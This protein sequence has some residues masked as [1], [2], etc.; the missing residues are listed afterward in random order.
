M[1]VYTP[2]K[3]GEPLWER[4]IVDEPLTWGHAVWCADLDGDGDDEL[5]IG[6]RDKSSDPTRKPSGPGVFI[7]D[8]RPG[9]E[10]LKFDRHVLDDG[11]MAAEDAVVADLDGD[12]RPDVI[13]G[14]PGDA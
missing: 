4:T 3:K 5:V 10:G 13:A 12:G 1:V 9:P 6:Q 8:P 2:P 14:G 11:G 7:Y